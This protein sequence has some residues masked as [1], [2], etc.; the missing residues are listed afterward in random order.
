MTI[1]G[2][3]L[4]SPEQV[5]VW[6]D[7][8]TFRAGGRPCGHLNKLVLNPLARLACV[9]TGTAAL[10][11]APVLMILQAEGLDG[12]APRVADR[13]RQT[14][15]TLARRQGADFCRG[16]AGE[17]LIL[18]GWS[19]AWHRMVL[20]R[21]CGADFFEP[22]LVGLAMRPEV[23]AP[24]GAEDLHGMAGVQLTSLREHYPEAAGGTLTFATLT[25]DALVTGTLDL[26]GADSSRA[27]GG[28][29]KTDTTHRPAAVTEAAAAGRPLPVSIMMEA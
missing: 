24:H 12:L 9:G 19:A 17:E 23:V 11:A 6:S 14:A 5:L 18:A 29:E 20:W 25:P 26:A 13:L 15:L 21:L 27:A 22:V 8:E 28:A 3:A 4:Q 1:C 2:A 10:L 7:T 16:F